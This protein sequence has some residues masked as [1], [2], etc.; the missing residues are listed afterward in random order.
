MMEIEEISDDVMVAFNL[1]EMISYLITAR[2]HVSQLADD[3]CHKS[4]AIGVLNALMDQL[5]TIDY[6]SVAH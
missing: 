3:G 5:T 2:E 4:A 6:E 1:E